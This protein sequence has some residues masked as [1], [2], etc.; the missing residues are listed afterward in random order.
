MKAK[1]KSLALLLAIVLAMVLTVTLA[2]CTKTYTITFDSAGGS[3]VGSITVKGKESP[4]APNAPTKEGHTFEKWIKPNGDEF[5]FGTDTVEEDLTLTAIWSKN[6]YTVRFVTGGGTSISPQS[7]GYN[8]KATRP[9][10]PNK[11]GEIFCDW[12]KDSG[13]KELFDFE[14]AIKSDT[15]VYARFELPSMYTYKVS[16]A[17]T[18]VAIADRETNEAGILTNLPKPE[19]S[20]KVFAGWWM[21]DFEDAGKLTC[22]Y[23]GQ[24]LTQNVTLFA[25]WES[26][27]PEVSVNESGVYWASEGVNVSYRVEITAPDGE[28]ESRTVGTT[29]YAY[30]FASKDAGEYKVEVTYNNKTT[31]VY[32]NNKA[33]SRVSVFEVDGFVL[34][35]NKVLNAEK[36]LVTVKCGNTSHEHEMKFTDMETTSGEI[37]FTL[38]EMTEEGIVFVVKAV[39]EGYVTSESEEYVFERHLDKVTGLSVKAEDETIIWNNVANAQYYEYQVNDGEWIRYDGTVSLKEMAAGAIVV[40]VRAVAHGYNSSEVAEYT[41]TKTR[42]ATPSKGSIE[43]D[44]TTLKWGAVAGA[45][46]YTVSIDG[47][48]HL[49][50]TGSSMELPDGIDW[51]NMQISVRANGA[52]ETEN[53]LYSEA[54][55]FAATLEGKIDYDEGYL[56][57]PTILG[58]S[59]YAVKVNGKDAVEVLGTATKYK[60]SLDREGTNV[61][62]ICYYDKA[63]EASE[64]ARIEVV[65]YKVTL[66]YNMEGYE[67]YATLYRA[68]NDPLELPDD[69]VTLVGYGFDYWMG[70][71]SGVE[72]TET[73]LTAAADLTLYAHWTANEYTVTFVVAGGT[74]SETTFK[75]TYRQNYVLPTPESD[76]VTK[77]FSGWYTAPGS[78]GIQYTDHTGAGKSVWSDAEGR[79]LY[80]GWIDVFEFSEITLNQDKGYS[81]KKGEGINLL[82]EVKIPAEYDGLPVIDISSGAFHGCNNLIKIYIPDTILNID[83]GSSGGKSTGSP[84]SNCYNLMDVEVYEVYPGEVY[85]KRY[86]SIDGALFEYRDKEN[87]SELQ[88]NYISYARTGRYD[89]PYGVTVLPISIFDDARFE[90]I[91]VPATVVKID[92]KA[93]ASGTYLKKIEFLAQPDGE[94]E[95]PLA[96]DDLAFSGASYV[97][98]L[99]LPTRFDFS[100]KYFSVLSNLEKISFTNDN[101]DYRAVDGLVVNKAADTIVYAPR[102]YKGTNGVLTIPLG[103]NKIADNAFSN[104]YL[105]Y[106]GNTSWYGVKGITKLVIPEYVTDIGL[107]AFR[108]CSNLTSVEFLGSGKSVQLKIA[109]GAFHS[110]SGLRK[111]TLPENLVSLGKYAFGY[112]TNLTEVEVYATAS[113]PDETDS[114]VMLCTALETDAFR[115]DVAWDKDNTR[116]AYSVTRVTIGANVGVMDLGGVFG[117]ALQQ[118]NIDPQNPNFTSDNGV[119][120][121]KN[122][123][124]IMFYPAARE[125]AFVLHGDVETISAGVFAK[126]AY[127]TE[128][129]LGAKVS[130][131]SEN[132]FNVKI[133][134]SS[135]SDNSLKITSALT[136]VNFATE[137]ADGHTLTIGDS[138]FEECKLLKELNL[139]DY[140]SAIGDRAF[141]LCTGLT[142]VTIPGSAKTLGDEVFAS[143]TGLETATFEEGVETIG[144]KLFIYCGGKLKTVNLPSTLT[145]IA[146]DDNEPFVNMFSNCDSVS[147]V[148]IAEGNEK[149]AS[150]DGIVYGYTLKGEDEDN[151]QNVL[152][153]LLYCP[154]GASG[155]DGVVDIPNTTERISAGAF[156]NNRN[157]T[158]IKFSQ[159]ILGDLDIGANAFSGCQKLATISLPTGLTTMKTGMFKGCASLVTINVPNT[160][161]KMEV[162]IFVGCTNLANIVFDEGN[163]SNILVMDDGEYSTDNDSGWTTSTLSSVFNGVTK[164]DVVV[165][166]ERLQKLSAYVFSFMYAPREVVL[167]GSLLEIGDYAFYSGS[168]YNGGYSDDEYE[169]KL[170]KVSFAQGVTPGLTTIGV[171]AF[172]YCSN[173]SKFDFVDSIEYIKAYAF[174]ECTSLKEV[175]FNVETSKLKK[176]GSDVKLS[177]IST[178]VSNGVFH[179]CTGL[180]TVVLPNS[181]EEIS[182]QES[183]SSGTFAN[184]TAL[185]NVSLPS[186]GKLKE[187]NTGFFYGCKSLETITIP[188]YIEKIGNSAFYNCI[189]LYE[190][191]FDVYPVEHQH[192]GKNS[193]ASI[194]DSAFSQTAL[195]SFYLPDSIAENGTT[196]GASIFNKVST[197]TSVELS[198]AVVSVDGVTQ[199]SYI[200]EISIPDDSRYLKADPVLPII[201]NKEGKI[202]QLTYGPLDD[203]D[204]AFRVPDGTEAITDKAFM[205][206]SFKKIILPYTIKSIGD[207]AFENC[208]MLEEIVF[209]TSAAGGGGYSNLATLGERAFYMCDSLKYIDLSKTQIKVLEN[210]T[211]YKCVALTSVVLPDTLTDIG[212]VGNGEGTSNDVF[213]G[214]TSLSNI[215][216]PK[217]LKNINGEDTFSYTALVEVVF[218]KTMEKIQAETFYNCEKLKTVTFQS[219]LNWTTSTS[220][221][222]IF[223]NSSVEKVVL[224]SGMETLGKN[225]FENAKQLKIVTY[226]GYVPKNQAD[227]EAGLEN[228]LPPLVTKV[229]YELFNNCSSLPSMDL[230]NITEFEV[231][232]TSSSNY[233][234]VFGNCTSLVKVTLNSSLTSLCGRMFEGCTALTSI[235]LPDSLTWLGYTE[236][237]ANTGLTSIKIPAGVTGLCQTS[238]NNSDKNTSLFSGC[239]SLTTVILPAGI[240]DFGIGGSVFKNC[241]AL[242]TIKV[243]EDGE[244]NVLSGVTLLGTNAFESAGIES[245]SLPD[246]TSIGASAFTKSKVKSVSL[247]QL[248]TLANSLFASCTSLTQV[249]LNDNAEALGNSMFEGCTALKTIT[250]PSNLTHLG[251]TTFKG[252]GITSI[253]IPDGVTHISDKSG[254]PAGTGVSVYVFQNCK[255]LES[256]TLP[257][258]LQTMGQY[259]FD[260]CSKLATVTYTSGTEEGNSLPQTL[261]LVGN[262]AFRN[263]TSLTNMKLPGVTTAGTYLFSGCTKLEKVVLGDY[264]TALPNYA[265]SG[266]SKLAEINLGAVATVGTY[267]FQNCKALKE[268]DFEKA[269]SIGATAFSGCTA[270]QTVNIP[271]ATSIGSS[272][273]KSCAL[274]TEVT[275]SDDASVTLGAS[276]FSGCTLLSQINL[277]SVKSVGANCFENCKMLATAELSN[278]TSVGNSAF[279]GCTALTTVKLPSVTSLGT[280]AFKGC[281][282]LNNVSL[283]GGLKQISESAFEN[284]TALEMLGLPSSLERIEAYAF[285]GSGLASL[286]LPSS[287]NYIDF[288]AFN[289]CANFAELTVSDPESG[290]YI[291]E[292][293]GWLMLSE[294]EDENKTVTLLMVLGSVQGEIVVPEGITAIGKSAFENSGITGIKLPS[295]LEIIGERAFYGSKLTSVTIPA[296]VLEIGAE[297]FS[298]SSV[299]TAV[300]D[301]KD[302]VFAESVFADCKSLVSV[303]FCTGLKALGDEMFVNCQALAEI[304]LPDGMTWLGVETFRNSG[305]VS[306]TLPDSV[307]HIGNQAGVAAALSTSNYLFADCAKLTTVVLSANLATMSAYCFNNCP[308]LANITYNGYEGEGNSLPESL[309]LVGSYAFNK[310]KALK[311]LNLPGVKE[312]GQQVFGSSTAASASAIEEVSLPAIESI[313]VSVFRNCT[314]LVSV[315]LNSNLKALGSYMFA[316]C[317]ALKNITLPEELTYMS[318]YTFQKSG[319]TSIVIP[320]KVQHMGNS[321][322]KEALTSHANYLFDGCADLTSVT[323]PAGLLTMGSNT[324]RNCTSLAS[325]TYAGYEG[326]YNALPVNLSVLGSNSF[327]SCAIENIIIPEALEKS[328]SSVFKGCSL[329]T[330]VFNAINMT[331]TSVFKDME[332]LT[333]VIFGDKVA[334]LAGQTFYGCTNLQNVTLPDSI[335]TIEYD[336]FR[337]CNAMTEIVL[338][339]N[340]ILDG[341]RVFWGWTEEQTI[342]VK[343]SAYFASQYWDTS[344]MESCNAKIV[345]DYVEAEEQAPDQPDN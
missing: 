224:Y 179:D 248:T 205:K 291:D 318:T 275:L 237:F 270:L 292:E 40:R 55:E 132:A 152:T 290:Y 80:A 166:P 259:V 50:E 339:K 68:Q 21:S 104:E 227:F 267:A 107:N 294:G 287:I 121:S 264:F 58:A 11:S 105:D 273:F 337:D 89:I 23:T 3:A 222:E 228:A 20:G 310:T 25:V 195:T 134:N 72:Y 309:T 256:V 191:E 144:V 245:L 210:D 168:W 27:N 239:T 192:A 316:N 308:M 231:Y 54:T 99:V 255:Q 143:C 246:L 260:G 158:E 163:E 286:A 160:V 131:I 249:V 202:I 178:T 22:E 244:N 39:G 288:S 238:G 142:E 29:E 19:E 307:E 120:Y 149:Y 78:N 289:G 175:V 213:N 241:S 88:L 135:V 181:L 171:R 303:D 111:V 320:S 180:V 129:T 345:W 26:E 176:L 325:V 102:T 336:A 216:L 28:K 65:A 82:T 234:A 77:A 184:C 272:A 220:Y 61:I 145:S 204:G 165:L 38:C 76:L 167:P 35:F 69:E 37:D 117:S 219:Q 296:S 331:T 172:E 141:A 297:A 344:W 125:G 45:V 94:T 150:I 247:P 4:S 64:W 284:C 138:A 233:N 302:A 148:N 161:N 212:T 67:D 154:V 57:W 1:R 140:V 30:D 10:D 335:E 324:F 187:L 257:A 7:V 133:Y 114:S 242:T 269:V 183:A 317:T 215:T 128:I 263:C 333:T 70:E 271:M 130:K 254:S 314:A 43:I 326:E 90:Y 34:K 49:V 252:S 46:S 280:S 253:V 75:V 155:V 33:L 243:G 62:E 109:S 194:G 278:A 115:T 274:L 283:G 277:A 91:S 73:K 323:L 319:L 153:D 334:Y 44:G 306:I 32:Y 330:V 189:S 265:F 250:L 223:Y 170:T 116:K 93:F 48:E 313:G 200:T 240:S 185:K 177:S 147:S 188:A 100:Y 101:W 136:K 211:F 42:L 119:V 74:M 112:C 15:T 6:T 139:P 126:A 207:S 343:S 71:S 208:K 232:N 322:D 196:L 47:V 225:L 266:C 123:S 305:L 83:Y 17:G 66:R 341:G 173:L 301:C 311:Q 24:V 197:L 190:V 60:I 262:Y 209:E 137:V 97:V 268:A 8:E 122:F 159:G 315:T 214:C 164:L 5:L 127:L 340:V 186:N 9:D 162:D 258:N 338:G 169:K 52:T 63:G 14:T 198:A 276:A 285:K 236:T 206:Q 261:T 18:A 193:L 56:V 201:Y 342:Y 146:I 31:T 332:S 2:A 156:Q 98:E 86:T 230:S 293:T 298:T 118:V 300:L 229:P 124:T 87:M 92:E 235:D 217:Y 151:K 199:G 304:E 312:L 59:K 95:L 110:C 81:V 329:T 36:Y 182:P 113:K 299:E 41:Y 106:S 174:G 226:D 79:I 203:K 157:I 85:E 12:Y 251:K 281:T 16:F 218:P 96:L 103:V 51:T 53:S 328:S 108:N 279:A 13:Y 295:T 327:E 84:F 221:G 321:A 282:K